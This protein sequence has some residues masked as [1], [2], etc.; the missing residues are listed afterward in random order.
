VHGTNTIIVTQIICGYGAEFLLK[1][2]TLVA[3][4]K[5]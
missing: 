2:R 3:Y 5:Q 4:L 1:R